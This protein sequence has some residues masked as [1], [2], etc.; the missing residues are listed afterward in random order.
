[1]SLISAVDE[2]E[3][4][5]DQLFLELGLDHEEPR[6]PGLVCGHEGGADLGQ[7]ELERGGPQPERRQGVFGSE[8]RD[9]RQSGQEL[10]VLL[11]GHTDH[12][13]QPIDHLPGAVVGDLIDG[14][15]R[16]VA[17]AHGLARLDQILPLQ[18]RRRRRR[19]SRS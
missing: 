3:L 1:M 4:G 13:G 5:R 7:L 11:G 17:V 6:Q 2:L 16:P 12:F 15:G 18:R 10:G 8:G 19:A 14:A 9:E